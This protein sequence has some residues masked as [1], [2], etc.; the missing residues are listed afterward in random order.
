MEEGVEVLIITDVQEGTMEDV[1]VE[2][3]GTVIMEH[4][5]QTLTR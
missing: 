2:V 4:L 1:E 5:E 3:V